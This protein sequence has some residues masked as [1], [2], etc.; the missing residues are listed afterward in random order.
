MRT[1]IFKHDRSKRWFNAN[2]QLQKKK[3]RRAERLCRKFPENITHLEIYRKCRNSYTTAIHQARIEYFSQK[4]ESFK[5]DSESLNNI[6]RD[7]SGNRKERILPSMENPAE[8]ANSMATF[9]VNKI[10]NIRTKIISEIENASSTN[11]SITEQKFSNNTTLSS[12]A[13]VTITEV[14]NI[15]RKLKKKFCIL[16]PAPTSIVMLFVDLIYPLIKRIINGLIFDAVFPELLKYGVVTPILKNP[17]LDSEL[18]NSF[19]PVFSLPFLCKVIE[20]VLHTQLDNH[21]K[22]HKLYSVYQSAYQQ[23]YS[24]ETAL[25]KLIDDFQLFHHHNQNVILILLDQSAAFDTVDHQKLLTRLKNTFGIDG[26]ALLLLKSYLE[27]RTFSVKLNNHLSNPKTLNYGVPQG[28][29]LGPLFY[30]LYIHPIDQIAIKHNFNI[31]IYADD[32]Q[33]YKPFINSNI[34]QIELDVHNFLE[35]MKIYISN[36]FLMLNKE[37]TLVKI[38]WHKNSE[39]N[40]DNILNYKL[41]SNIKVLGVNLENC[42]D[43]KPFIQNKTKI[44]NM[45]L[46]NLYNIRQSLDT[47]TRI[48]MITNLILST[49]DYCSFLLILCNNKELQ[50]LKIIM[51]RCMRFI[52]NVKFRQHV[53][54]FY[55][56]CHFL[57]IN[58][59][60]LFKSCLMAH[61]IYFSK[62]PSYLEEKIQ[63]YTPTIQN[64]TLRVGPG[65]DTFMFA[66]SVKEDNKSIM[67]AMKEKWNVLPLELRKLENTAKFKTRLKTHLLSSQSTLTVT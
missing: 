33:I 55:L 19:R 4:I 39:P 44:C 25:S 32:C 65:R 36:N 26:N 31:Q 66:T 18:F 8:T 28:S 42:F 49:I 51:N 54:P 64:M 62:A 47:K 34:K 5:W 27:H 12:F 7:L 58:N 41:Q 35:D 45:H 59:R 40:T 23:N 29:L 3:K 13:Q 14:Q 38:F 10:K 43:F 63:R 48:L 30:I 60:I 2:I 61:K 46:R 53:T 50:P 52:Y 21:L 15:I 24:C 9:Y 22:H 37:K 1:R 20:Q 17:L 57:N 16:D 6:L 11:I 56:K 67:N